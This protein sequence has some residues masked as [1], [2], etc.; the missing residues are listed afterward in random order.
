MR[1]GMSRR[2]RS[3][4]AY[5]RPR[6]VLFARRPSRRRAFLLLLPEPASAHHLNRPH[7]PQPVRVVSPTATSTVTIA[8]RRT[9]A[10]SVLTRNYHRVAVTRRTRYVFRNLECDRT[11]RLGVR[12]LDRRGRRSR[13]HRPRSSARSRATQPPVPSPP[14]VVRRPPRSHRRRARRTRPAREPG[15]LERHASAELR[16]PV[17]ALR[18]RRARLRRRSPAPPARTTSSATPTSARRCARRSRPPTRRLGLGPRR[19]TT[20]VSAA[21]DSGSCSR[22]DATG[23]AAVAGSRI[24]LLNQRFSCDRSLAEIAAEQPDRRRRRAACR[25]WSRSASRP[26]S[27]STRP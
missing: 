22:S 17:A 4:A 11:Y 16:L 26:T 20:L 24:S 27:T 19:Q 2:T 1:A 5:P 25:S 18:R 23:C 6:R 13:R 14:A 7:A 12:A 10:R 8:W 9:A 15:H 21:G 3:A